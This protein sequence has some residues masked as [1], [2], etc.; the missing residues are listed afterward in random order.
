[1]SED[2]GGQPA[3]SPAG[4]RL[5][6]RLGQRMVA[7]DIGYADD[8]RLSIGDAQVLFSGMFTSYGLGGANYA[9]TPD[10]EH[11]I[12]LEATDRGDSYS[13]IQLV[14]NWQDEVHA[15]LERAAAR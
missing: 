15:L 1:M 12:M 9:L 13:D 8:G 6:Y 5:Y 11:F 14:V 7:V 10:G 4:D 2:G 3:W